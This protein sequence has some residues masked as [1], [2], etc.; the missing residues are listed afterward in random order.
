V[1]VYYHKHVTD[2]LE[3]SLSKLREKNSNR[4]IVVFIDDLDR[5]HPKQ[6]LEVLDSIKTFFDIEGLIYV[7]GM[8][9]GS[10]NSIIEEKYGGKDSDIKVKKGLLFAENCSTSFPDSDLEGDRYIQ[11]YEQNHLKRTSRLRSGRSV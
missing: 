6:A 8:D 5:C 9:S 4:R 11:V 1:S 3:D 7:I 10:I 2:Y